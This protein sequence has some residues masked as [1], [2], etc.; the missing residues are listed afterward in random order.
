MI[1]EKRK[2]KNV[3]DQNGVKKY[4]KLKNAMNRECKKKRSVLNNI[5]QD[6]NEALNLGLKDKAYEMVKR[7]FGE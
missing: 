2:Y 3:T 5:C 4:K 7:Y 1:N 6:I